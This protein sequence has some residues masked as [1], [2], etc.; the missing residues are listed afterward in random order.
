MLLITSATVIIIEVLIEC[1]FDI[2]MLAFLRQRTLQPGAAY[3]GR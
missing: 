3:P 2:L 1:I